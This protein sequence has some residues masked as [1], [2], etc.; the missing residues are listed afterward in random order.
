MTALTLTDQTDDS[1]TIRDDEDGAIVSVSESVNVA[2]FK[3]DALQMRQLWSW[4][5]TALMEI[6][7]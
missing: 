6:R 5:A 2:S 4:L 3:L 7:A 1:L